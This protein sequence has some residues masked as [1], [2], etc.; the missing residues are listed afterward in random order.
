MRGLRVSERA[1]PATGEP[2]FPGRFP[3]GKGRFHVATLAEEIEFIQGL[4]RS[5]GRNVGIYP[6]I[7]APAWHREEG[8]DISRSVLRVLRNYGYDH[9]A[10]NAFL[11]C[12]D[13]SELI[14]IRS[15]LGA[16][17]KLVQLLGGRNTELMS[18]EG[19]ARISEY[20]QG[21]GPSI[22]HIIP[23]DRADAE[24]KALASSL[25]KRAGTR[26]LLVHPYT[27]RAD[28]LPPFATGFDELLSIFYNEIGVDGVFTDHPDRVVRFLARRSAGSV[29]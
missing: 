26:G 5:S 1:D 9:I 10:S 8:H 23:P 12:F 22:W 7:K 20:A 17:I 29:E 13:A 4:N 19:L 18:S 24:F 15:K 11:Q 6:E 16:Q 27:F 2:F 25:V 21:I 28:A 14:R 3:S